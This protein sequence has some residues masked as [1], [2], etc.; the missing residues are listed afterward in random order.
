MLSLEE[1]VERLP[2]KLRAVATKLRDFCEKLGGTLIWYQSSRTGYTFSC[3]LPR[4]VDVVTVV[5]LHGRVSLLLAE[6]SEA[7]ISLS[8]SVDLRLETTNASTVLI[9]EK[10]HCKLIL[11]KRTDKIELVLDMHGRLELRI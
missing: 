3:S 10:D 2:E 5:S 11:S 8:E 1:V 6:S 9:R 4:E 7:Q